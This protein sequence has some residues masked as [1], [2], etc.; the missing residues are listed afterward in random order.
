MSAVSY[1]IH[2]TFG[3]IVS[4]GECD[5]TIVDFQDIPQG[6]TLLKN[7]QGHWSTHYVA[8]GALVDIPPKPSE[9]YIFDYEVK[10]W[11]WANSLAL[12]NIRTKRNELLTRSDWTQLPDVVLSTKQAWALYRQA[13]RDITEQP[14]LD[15]IVWPTPPQ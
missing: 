12:E 6:C 1:V 10:Q 5:E 11:V 8:N 13:L 14:D 2:D 9:N 4:I 15:N 7:V 3:K